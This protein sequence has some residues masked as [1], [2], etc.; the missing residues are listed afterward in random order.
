[1]NRKN[2]AMCLVGFLALT[3]ASRAV[4]GDTNV[5]GGD[6]VLTT[7]NPAIITHL[8]SY[9]MT[10]WKVF[11][12]WNGLNPDNSGSATSPPMSTTYSVVVETDTD[13]RVYNVKPLAFLDGGGDVYYFAP[14]D[15]P[16]VFTEVQQ[17]SGVTQNFSECVGLIQVHFVDGGGASI[18]VRGG[19]MTASEGGLTRAVDHGFPDPSGDVELIVPADPSATYDLRVDF[20]LNSDPYVDKV[21]L[22]VDFPG[23]VVACDDVVDLYVDVTLGAGGGALGAISAAV[24]LDDEDEINETGWTFVRAFNGPLGNFR[25]GIVPGP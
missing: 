1:M 2:A 13:G 20:N 8:N 11:A 21:T 25:Y 5:I 14:Q 12:T 18:Q 3:P 7:S 6:L 17:P 16:A 15:A 19:S 24:D 23:V 22:R 4:D 10:G 9:G